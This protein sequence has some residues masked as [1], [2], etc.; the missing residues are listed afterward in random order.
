MIK[1]T[2]I[3][4]ISNENLQIDLL[5]IALQGNTCAKDRLDL[6]GIIE[7]ALADTEGDN[8]NSKTDDVTEDPQAIEITFTDN[9]LSVVIAELNKYLSPEKVQRARKIFRVFEQNASPDELESGSV[10]SRVRCIFSKI[11]FDF[12]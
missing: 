9:Q 3:T 6:K 1:I 12:D 4:L 10:G 7:T 2:K 5:T 11:I 8:N